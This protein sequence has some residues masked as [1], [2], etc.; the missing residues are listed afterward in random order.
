V[1][2][3]VVSSALDLSRSHGE[4]R[5]GSV[6]G[7][8]LCLFIHAQRQGPFGRVQIE[9]HDVSDFFDEQRVAR[10]LEGFEPVGLQ[11]EGAPA[12]GCSSASRWTAAI[13]A[14]RSMRL[15]P[16]RR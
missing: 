6:Q 13:P 2:F 9:P 15:P 7:L 1:A 8:D 4:Q 3:A 12:V 10:Q 16:A 14:S 11:G 5:L